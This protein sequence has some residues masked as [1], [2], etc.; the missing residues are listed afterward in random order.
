MPTHSEL[1]AQLLRDAASFFRT[2]G[3]QNAPMKDQMAE[4]A[5]VFDEVAVL[6]EA[7]PLGEISGDM[8]SD[9]DGCCGGHD[10]NHDHDHDDKQGGC[11]GGGCGHSH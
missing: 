6:V 5:A 1:A 10:H 11:G 7:D 4:N 9:E 3:E 8:S 2:I